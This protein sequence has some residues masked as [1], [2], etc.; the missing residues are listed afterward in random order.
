M[1]ILVMS[2]SHSALDFMRRCVEKI[3]PDVMIHLGD[4]YQDASDIR[5][6]HPE[7][8]FYQVP[9]NCDRFRC[10]PDTAE[11]LVQRIGGVRIYMTHGHL[12]QVKWSTDSLVA[13]AKREKADIVLYGHTH[14]PE[15]RKDEDGMWI[16]NPG[17]CGYYGG[18]VGIIEIN[19]GKIANCWI[20]NQRFLE[21]SV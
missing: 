13:D 2:D 1:K 15:C 8:P 3:R 10:I 21:D 14:H 19:D 18:T 4:Y 11:T 20:L 7:I 12:H 5:W 17:S 9:G 16:M 6:E